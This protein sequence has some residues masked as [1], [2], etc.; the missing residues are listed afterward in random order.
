MATETEI[1]LSLSVSAA[2][3]L[4]QHPLLAGLERDRQLLVSTYYDTPD[5]RLQGRADC[6]ALPPEGT[7][8]VAAGGQDCSAACC[9]AGATQRVGG[10]GAAGRVR[11]FAHVDSND[12]CANCLKRCAS[13][14]QP[15]FKTHFRRDLWLLE[16]RP[17]GAHRSG[18]RPW[19]DRR[20]AVGA[21]PSARSNWNCSLASLGTCSRWPGSCRTACRCTRR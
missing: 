1:K 9:R 18:A 2:N 4:A 7:S 11:F 21:C 6:R 16:R 14:L 17:R 19:V 5:R 10:S 20:A 3:Q 12:V 13:E 8:S 15:V